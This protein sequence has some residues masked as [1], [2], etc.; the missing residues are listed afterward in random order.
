[1]GCGV[2]AA[3]W[4]V[5]GLEEDMEIK[6]GAVKAVTE[7]EM[8][9]EM[10]VP[11]GAVAMVRARMEVMEE[12]M[13]VAHRDMAEVRNHILYYF[14]RYTDIPFIKPCVRYG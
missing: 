12:V 14:L 11:N 8:D 9:G 2:A 6:V 4:L 13:E 10:E 3:Q 5:L 1:M 7:V